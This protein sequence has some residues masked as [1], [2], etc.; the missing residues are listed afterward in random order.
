[1]HTHLYG[2][3]HF[4]SL[5]ILSVIIVMYVLRCNINVHVPTGAGKTIGKL[6]WS[7]KQLTFSCDNKFELE[8][9]IFVHHMYEYVLHTKG[10][11][12]ST[13]ASLI[14]TSLCWDIHSFGS[15]VTGISTCSSSASFPSVPSP[16]SSP[17]SF[18]GYT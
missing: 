12:F 10:L 9:K 5:N 16:S 2:Y 15:G 11:L 3:F 14:S 18:G 1:M 17:S 7:T 8:W 6:K 13:T 4:H